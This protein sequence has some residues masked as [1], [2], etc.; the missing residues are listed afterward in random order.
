[1]RPLDCFLGLSSKDVVPLEPQ[2]RKRIDQIEVYRTRRREA[3]SDD[4]QKVKQNND[5]FQLLVLQSQPQRC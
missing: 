2:Q 3:E 5:A 4:Q 1:M